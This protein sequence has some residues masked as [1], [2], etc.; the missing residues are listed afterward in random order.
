MSYFFN[1]II[2]A[3]SG[4]VS[5]FDAITIVMQLIS[6]NFL[7]DQYFNLSN[8]SINEMGAKLGKLASRANKFYFARFIVLCIN[9]LVK[10]VTIDNAED[11]LICWV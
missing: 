2:K 4:K 11:Q 8:M 9:H 7:H 10:D 6:Y 3:F 5:N 1:T